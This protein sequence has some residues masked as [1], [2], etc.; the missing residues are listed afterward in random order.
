LKAG[1]I[2][3]CPHCMT[4]TLKEVCKVCGSKTVSP[5]PVHFT[6]SSKHASLLLRPGKRVQAAGFLT[7][8]ETLLKERM[9]ARD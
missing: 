6:P 9:G 4:Y 8:A 7:T 3:K 2:R 1:R 5:H